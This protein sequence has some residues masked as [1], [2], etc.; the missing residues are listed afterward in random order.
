MLRCLKS[1]I[2]R[3]H[4]TDRRRLAFRSLSPYADPTRGRKTFT[5]AGA[6]L[7]GVGQD[8]QFNSAIIGAPAVLQLVDGGDN[9]TPW[10]AGFRVA[11]D[12]QFLTTEVGQR[13]RILAAPVNEQLSCA[14]DVGVRD[15]RRS[16]KTIAAGRADAY[17][18]LHVM[19]GA[20]W[21]N[22]RACS[23]DSRALI[24]GPNLG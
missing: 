17:R 5:P 15:H 13:G 21:R 14:E 19:R 11:S 23:Q 3:R 6:G 2:R 24:P 20:R 1:I 8:S 10:L 16:P 4:I 12:T 9:L 18:K 22:L 7:R